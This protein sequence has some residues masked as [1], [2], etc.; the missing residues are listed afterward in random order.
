MPKTELNAKLIEINILTYKKVKIKYFFLEYLATALIIILK[1]STSEFSVFQTLGLMCWIAIPALVV[2]LKPIAN[3][4]LLGD[5]VTFSKLLRHKIPKTK[6]KSLDESTHLSFQINCSCKRF[7]NSM[8]G[9]IIH[10]KCIENL[11]VSH[12]L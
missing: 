5:L 12:A 10:S 9:Q 6:K 2:G 8:Q 11:C 4:S 7:A 3:C 1:N